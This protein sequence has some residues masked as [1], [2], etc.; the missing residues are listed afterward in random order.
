MRK[1]V[2]ISILHF[3]QMWANGTPSLQWF[4]RC[5]ERVLCRL[6]CRCVISLRFKV[7]PCCFSRGP[8]PALWDRFSL[9]SLASISFCLFLLVPWSC[10]L[11]WTSNRYGARQSCRLLL[12]VTP[13]FLPRSHIFSFSQGRI[14]FCYSV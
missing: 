7:G 14:Q 11:Y 2:G 8:R 6:I 10:F 5:R 12:P 13:T 1:W 4:W 3:L 9:L